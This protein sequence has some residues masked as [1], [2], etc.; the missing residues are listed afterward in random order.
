MAASK[1]RQIIEAIVARLAAID[2]SGEFETKAG[3]QIFM[4]ELPPFGP[5]D[6]DYAIAVQY[7]DD[8]PTVQ[9]G[10]VLHV[11]TVVLLALARVDLQYDEDPMIVAERVLAD[12][13]RA[14]ELA[15][16]DLGG[17]V[18]RELLAGPIQTAE[19]EAGATSCG[20]QVAYVVHYQRSWGSP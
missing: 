9:Q 1:R 20:V 19:M 13:Q 18:D 10:K 12:I 7:G 5:D 4:N 3:E 17:L 14:I 15:D 8:L 16:R 6:P 11:L 2:G